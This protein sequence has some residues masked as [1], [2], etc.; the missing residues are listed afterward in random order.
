M[1]SRSIE[2]SGLNRS[3]QAGNPAPAR[4]KTCTVRGFEAIKTT[5]QK[6]AIHRDR[7]DRRRTTLFSADSAKNPNRLNTLAALQKSP[8]LWA[9]HLR[10]LLK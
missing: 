6:A 4:F 10:I 9:T 1:S 7:R 8:E 2:P 5:L 3:A